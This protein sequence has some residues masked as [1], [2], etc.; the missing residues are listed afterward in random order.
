MTESRMSNAAQEAATLGDAL[1][2][3]RPTESSTESPDLPPNVA[4]GGTLSTHTPWE[5]RLELTLEGGADAVEA[6]A[7]GG[8][9]TLVA[10]AEEEDDVVLMDEAVEALDPEGF[11]SLDIL[12]WKL[13]AEH[14]ASEHLLSLGYGQDEPAA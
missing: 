12:T 10:R 5:Y 1:G 7:T 4:F 11:S 6:G 2:I 9:L 14:L 13:R 8:Q 3:T